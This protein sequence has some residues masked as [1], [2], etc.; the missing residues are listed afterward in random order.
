MSDVI[1]LLPDNIANQIAAGEVIQRPASVVKELVENA[2]DAGSTRID[3]NIKDAGRTLIQVVDNGKGMSA[4]D[5]TLCFERHAT[6]KVRTADDLFALSTKGFRGEALASIAA[7]AH[8]EMRTKE[9]DASTGSS[10]TIEGSSIQNQEEIVCPTGTSFSVKNLFY[11]VPARRN[12]LKKDSTEFRHIQDEFDR[13]CLAHPDIE[14]SL[15]HNENEI[16][17]LPSEILRKRIAQ[18]LGKK[19]NELLVPIQEET[20]IVKVTGFVV[21]PEASR[22]TRGDQYFFVNNRYFKSPY[23][24]HAISKAFDGLIQSKSYPGYFIYLEVDP[25][26]ID[27]NVH[28]TKTEIKFEEDKFIYAILYSSVKQALGKY[29]I[30]PTLDFEAETSFE[31]PAHIRKQPPVEPQIHVN[32]DYNPF[33]EFKKE[34]LGS[35]RSHGVKSTRS[36]AISAAGFGSS[37]SSQEWQD[38]YNIEDEKAQENE[39]IFEHSETLPENYLLNG[40]HILFNSEK[41]LKIVNW[42]RAIERIVYDD[43]SQKFVSQPLSSQ[44]LLFPYDVEASRKECA[45]WME[46]TS[47]LKQMGFEGSVDGEKIILEAI[48][49]VLQEESI[50][51]A[52]ESVLESLNNDQLEKGDLAHYILS[53]ISSA[54]GLCQ[55]NLST[56]DAVHEL[57]NQL[58]HCEDSNFTPRNKK[59]SSYLSL[60]SIQDLFI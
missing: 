51:G 36:T 32:P 21:K 7:I 10:V 19:S 56:K 18:L 46:N 29:N 55:H 20:D 43:I 44:K 2:I 17:K 28:P 39:T 60:R 6:S 12:F 52:M 30:V 35:S 45:L 24:N 8:V 16:Y 41:G 58:Q 49:A 34:S 1:K 11:N 42:R 38:F 48:P 33:E 9:K 40:S 47:I 59:I 4:A 22:K 31:V 27:V 15:T 25:A 57:L 3:I 14:F 37:G 23:F 54:A 5:A 13:I 50:N 26:K 53:S